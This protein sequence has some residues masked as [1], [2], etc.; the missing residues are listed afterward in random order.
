MKTYYLG[1]NGESKGPYVKEQILAM[2]N[3]G[4]IQAD[5]LYFNESSNEWKPV[6]DIISE[7][8]GSTKSSKSNNL[9]EPIPA[10][11]TFNVF[12]GTL[13]AMVVFAVI[14]FTLLGIKQYSEAKEKSRKIAEQAKWDLCNSFT[15]VRLRG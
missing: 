15:S 5:T 11:T 3:S 10:T 9:S 4:N 13:S 2:W 6:A 14:V 7:L 12:H 1:I 8:S